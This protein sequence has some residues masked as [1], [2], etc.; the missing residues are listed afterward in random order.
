[1]GETGRA[2]GLAGRGLAT[3][4]AAMLAL[5]GCS[6]VTPKPSTAHVSAEQSPPPSG[7]IPAPVQ[8]VP[9][10]PLPTPATRPETYSAVSYTHL[11]LPTKRIV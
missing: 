2:G 10:L 9:V 8:V 4:A 5:A 11:T 6:G 7:A 3:I 1:M